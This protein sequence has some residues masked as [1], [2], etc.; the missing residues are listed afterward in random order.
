MS[1]SFD[2][3]TLTCRKLSIIDYSVDMS[4]G[5]YDEEKRKTQNVVFTVD[6]WVPMA[7][8]ADSYWD[9]T[10]IVQA[11]DAIVAGGHVGLQEEIHTLLFERLFA[12]KRV[13]A[14]RILTKKTQALARAAAAAVETFRFN[15]DFQA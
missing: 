9:Y 15:P 3:L 4:V 13:R 1:D 2:T 7:D 8:G 10:A 12:D 6:V 5:V 11:V 14:V